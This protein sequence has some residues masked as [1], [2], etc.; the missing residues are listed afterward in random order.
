M[1]SSGL[2]KYAIWLAAVSYS[3]V[4]NAAT[5]PQGWAIVPSATED[6]D[7][8][9]PK[10][11]Q[12]PQLAR[13]G[14]RLDEVDIV[15]ALP[16]DQVLPVVVAALKPL[17]PLHEEAGRNP[18]SRMDDAWGDVL[19]TRRPDLVKDLV[20][21]F[22]L[23]RLEQD[24]RDGA[25]VASEIPD[26]MAR[27]ERSMRF[28]S[29][30][31]RMALLTEPF[32][33]WSG[34]AERTHG[35]L[36]RST[37][38]AIANVTQLDAVL[39]HPATAVHLTR[40]DDYPNPR[41][42]VIGQMRNAAGLNIF[43]PGPPKRLHR[44]SVPEDLFGPVFDAL[45][46]LPH[47]D[48]ELG[49]S[50]EH[51]RAPSP[52][53]PAPT[54]PKL[55][56]PDAHAEV[57]KA[58]A[59]VSFKAMNDFAVLADGSVL[60][61][62]RYPQALLHWSPHA[63]GEPRELWTPSTFFTK[64]LLSREANGQAAYMTADGLVMRFDAT[65]GSLAKHP[66]AFDTATEPDD[67]YMSY[68]HDGHGVPLTYRHDY[69]AGRDTL[70]VWQAVAPPMA[71]GT[72][73]QYTR[74]FASPRQDMMKGSM[75]GNGQIKPVRW[76]GAMANT[77]V[78]D[79]YG[80]TELD[81]K[82]GRVRR[83]VTLPRRFGEVD[84]TDDT[85]MAQWTPEP[86]GSVKG[87]WIAVGFVLMEGK[88]RHPGVHVVDVASGKLRYSLTLPGQD[89]LGTAVGSPDG[90]RLALGPGTGKTVAV[91]W[92][93][94]SGRSLTLQADAAGCRGLTQLQWSPSGQRLWGR[95]ENGLVAWD[96]PSDG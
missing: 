76:D 83:V 73:W 48:V 34:S 42:G 74:R 91:L 94:D 92:N 88:T 35:A 19:L 43:S 22:D 41:G 65:T 72:R 24:V 15:V 89:S 52:P 62:R 29:D 66:M 14:Q 27:M 78:E 55:T 63:S 95:C 61:V 39:G 96:V 64:W 8:G 6:I 28:R 26:R 50:A 87:G 2:R 56:A 59:I 12:S 51:W 70:D 33:Y 60:L 37:S 30:S 5:L 21:R 77:W 13:G 1:K 71:D 85:G 40:N 67:G 80:L 58:Q 10:A 20:R 38:I 81:G 46:K 54:E 57:L 84:P 68:F 7:G 4:S 36:G 75:R 11:L 3:G 23:P 32:A 47:A 44:S 86:F 49:L 53:G 90:H 16:F 79:V 9:L 69:R 82:T 17:G 45:S 31:E 18:L 25:L 93:L